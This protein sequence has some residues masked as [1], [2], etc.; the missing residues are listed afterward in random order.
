M[1]W[2]YSKTNSVMARNSSK[3]LGTEGLGGHENKVINNIN[4]KIIRDF[5]GDAILMP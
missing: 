2:G 1:S 4:V 5:P 3:G